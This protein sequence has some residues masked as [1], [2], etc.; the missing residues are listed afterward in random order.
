VTYL[1]AFVKQ[2]DGSRCGWHNC[3][4]ASHVMAADRHIRGGKP[5][6][7]AT[8][9]K[10]S[11]GF[12]RDRITPSS[13]GATSDDQNDKVL[14]DVFGID[15][16]V[17]Y[18]LPW[19]DFETVLKSGRGA[20]IGISYSVIHGTKFDACPRFLGN[21][22]VYDNEIRPSDGFHRIGD[23]LADGRFLSSTGKIAPKGWQWWPPELVKKAAGAHATSSG[24]IGVGFID[25]SITADTEDEEMASVVPISDESPKLIGWTPGAQF[26]R[27]DGSPLVTATNTIPDL[28]ANK[29]PRFSPF[30]ARVNGQ[31]FRVIFITTDKVKQLALCRPG[32]PKLT[33]SNVS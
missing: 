3:N 23:P 13:C 11:P 7:G 5:A 20:K 25:C 2:G 24:T 1:P 17:R 10:P 29:P 32:D 22:S 12:I 4:P 21:H 27:L 9:W 18:R 31:E 6:K 8:S 14:R 30:G 28:A 16:D 33:V 26:F 15:L 19:A